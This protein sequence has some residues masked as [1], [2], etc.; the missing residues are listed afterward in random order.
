M[1]KHWMPVTWR[2]EH[3]VGA[4]SRLQM[5]MLLMNHIR[6]EN[7]AIRH[8]VWCFML[9]S[10]ALSHLFLIHIDLWP[11]FLHCSVQCTAG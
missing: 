11:G 6:D 7:A 4:V 2:Y 10:A 8:A 3:L 5:L 9:R 1:A